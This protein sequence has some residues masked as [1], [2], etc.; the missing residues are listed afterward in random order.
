M[1]K[2]TYCLLRASLAQISR[3]NILS[4]LNVFSSWQIM[5][6]NSVSVNFGELGA[7]AIGNSSRGRSSIIIGGVRA[8]LSNIEYNECIAISDGLG[9]EYFRLS[10][11]NK[12]DTW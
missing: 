1:I 11:E 2:N 10:P 5:F 7:G 3:K 8:L 6:F 4:S 9:T 12:T